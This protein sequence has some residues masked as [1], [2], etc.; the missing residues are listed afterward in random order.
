MR[1]QV[2]AVWVLLGLT[3]A[4]AAAGAG[5]SLAQTAPRAAPTGPPATRVGNVRD[6]LHGVEIVDP[7]RWL[8]EQQSPETREWIA[9]QNRYTDALLA[10]R[11]TLAELRTRLAGLMRSDRMSVPLVRGSHYFFSVQ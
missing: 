3:L 1:R 11:P 7:Y 8:E 10:T 2:L 4:L 9:A 6:V 5:S